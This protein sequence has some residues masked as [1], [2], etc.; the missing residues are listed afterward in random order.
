MVAGRGLVIEFGGVV[1]DHIPNPIG[2]CFIGISLEFM[3][4]VD[5][6]DRGGQS[7]L[8]LLFGLKVKAGC[9]WNEWR[10]GLDVSKYDIKKKGYCGFL[11]IAPDWDP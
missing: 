4:E 7:L 8:N 5:G 11:T 2:S 6:N 9:G 10:L 1:V 3:V